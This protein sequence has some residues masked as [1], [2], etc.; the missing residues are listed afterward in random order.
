MIRGKVRLPSGAGVPQ[1]EV[2]LKESR[3]M[4]TTTDSGF[5]VFVGVSPGVYT[6]GIHKGDVGTAVVRNIVVHVDLAARVFV[7]F[8]NGKAS[9]R[10]YFR[11]MV[12][13][14]GTIRYLSGRRLRFMPIE[15][16]AQGIRVLPSRAEID[17]YF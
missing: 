2:F 11:N 17:R 8:D 5:F 15:I 9:V 7:T 13:E 10:H 6:V 4:V 16:P 3:R 1:A 12:L 14:P